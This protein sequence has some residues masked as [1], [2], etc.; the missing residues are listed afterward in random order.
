MSPFLA[1][2][3][4]DPVIS[5]VKLI[6]EPWDVGHDGY[7]VGNFPVLW[8]EW[9]GRYRDTVRRY[10]KGDDAQA[11]D[12]AFRLCGSS[13][14]Y[15]HNGKRPYASINFLTSHDGF[16]LNDLVS[17]NDK[18]NEENGEENRDGDNHNHS[19]NCGV[20]GE[21]DDPEINALRQRQRRNLL[22]TLLLSQGVP[23][24][25]AGDECGRTQ[26]GNNNAYCQDNEISWFD[27]SRLA[28]P[29]SKRLLEFTRRLI[30]L[31]HDHPI[32]RRPKF[33]Q[34]RKIRGS[35]VKDVM[36][37][38]P[39]GTEMTDDEWH[40][41]Y[42]RSIGLFLSGRTMDVRDEQ[43]RLIE[44]DSFLILLNAHHAS[45]PFVLPGRRDAR[46]ELVLDTAIE[47]G[48]IPADRREYQGSSTLALRE[49]SLC[50]LKLGGGT[51]VESALLVM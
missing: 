30:R 8:A 45:M 37:F 29:E 40:M 19:W 20:E 31:R 39:P 26:R 5:R 46:W 32:F 14:L 11:A 4:Q 15:R 48:E 36:W 42:V 6:A 41:H 24:I 33:F 13:D 3:H 2:V 28:D 23:M 17:Y 7:H 18:H 16:T 9:N 50:L 21:T 51:S 34:G 10:W 12:L 1:I 22:A 44:D 38:S 25:C 27:W 47:D 43:G 35:E 49:R